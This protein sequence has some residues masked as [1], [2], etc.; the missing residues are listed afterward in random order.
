MKT[1]VALA[2]GA[3]LGWSGLSHLAVAQTSLDESLDQNSDKAPT[4]QIAAP[5]DEPTWYNCLTREVWSPE[6]QAWCDLLR[7]MQ[8]L[9]YTVPYYGAVVLNNGFYENTEQRWQVS[10]INQAGLIDFGDL[11]GD[12]TADDAIALLLVNSG[13]SGQFVY[14]APVLDVATDPQ[15]LGTV[16]LGDRV[17]VN[18][19]GI[20]DGQVTLN[21]V[22]QD[23]DDPL[24]CPTLE[25]TQVYQVQ[26]ALVQVSGDLLAP[27]TLP[28]PL[29]DRSETDE[30]PDKVEG[31]ILIQ[32][33]TN[34]YIVRV[35]QEDEQTK[36][37]LYNK[38]SQGLDLNGVPVTVEETP[39]G[40]SYLYEGELTVRV[41]DSA[42]GKDSLVINGDVQP[43]D[44]TS[45]DLA[46]ITGTVAYRQRIALPPTAIIEVQ[47]QDV[48]LQ[49]A[50]AVILASETI[51]SDGRQVPIPFSLSYD[52]DEIN[53]R[54]TY[55]VRASI[56]VDDQLRFTST[57]SYPV[58]TNG[59]PHQVDIIVEPVTSAGNR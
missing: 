17:R 40:T 25:V 51:E 36:I 4:T 55:A 19:V 30:F 22:T 38:A 15:P 24:C 31:E 16:F 58:I 20:D 34:D 9:E 33:D 59:N 14:L 12:G 49:D 46:T 47:L 41:F 56:Y 53:P 27:M 50:A 7:T 21:M 54:H 18:A 29:P 39:E 13:G 45:S 35:Y 37:D 42:Y 2:L 48:S 23:A 8:G 11:D 52:A 10:L 6:K 32:L 1:I 3:G 43:D 26:P 5:D 28:G 57:T 44:Q